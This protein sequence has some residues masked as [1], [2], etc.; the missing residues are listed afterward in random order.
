MD[1]D[2]GNQ[3]NR[4]KLCKIWSL[5]T[6]EALGTGLRTERGALRIAMLESAN[7]RRHA[8]PHGRHACNC[9]L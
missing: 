6:C 1:D 7:S 4:A 5:L 9:R 3:N 2:P 8:R